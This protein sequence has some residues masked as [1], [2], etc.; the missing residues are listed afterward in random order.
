M[1]EWWILYKPKVK[2]K[3]LGRLAGKV[4]RLLRGVAKGD[5][6]ASSY[7]DANEDLKQS[8][9]FNFQAY[10]SGKRRMHEIEKMKAMI[11]T[12][13]RHQSWKAGGPV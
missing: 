5:F 12:E 4:L 11:I 6:S 2:L 1:K 7:T 9:A 10:I 3:S 13:S 8:K